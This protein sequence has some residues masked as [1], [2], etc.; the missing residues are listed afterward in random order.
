MLGDT[1]E[2]AK[3]KW[4]IKDAS[5]SESEINVYLM[6]KIFGQLEGGEEAK[7]ECLKEPEEN[8]LFDTDYWVDYYDNVYDDLARS[9]QSPGQKMRAY[10]Y[11][12]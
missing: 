3:R 9:K 10:E 4:L 6:T 8:E 11:K 7:N 1:C 5:S 2:Y 12:E